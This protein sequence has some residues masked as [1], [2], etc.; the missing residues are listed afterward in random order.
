[1]RCSRARRSARPV[2]ACVTSAR[3]SAAAA[4]ADGASRSA[5][6]FERRTENIQAHEACELGRGQV[7]LVARFDQQHPLAGF[8]R[9]GRGD[10]VWRNE[11]GV[12][13][14]A[15]VPD[16]GLRAG[17]ALLEDALGRPGG[18]ERPERASNLEAKVGPRRRD[19]GRRRGRLRLR[20]ALERIAAAAVV[21]RPLEIEPRPVVVRH[22]RIDDAG[23]PADR[24]G[25]GELRDV[26]RARVSG[27][28]RDERLIGCCPHRDGSLGGRFPRPRLGQAMAGLLG[29]RLRVLER[30]EHAAPGLG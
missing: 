27:G 3:A 16:V 26:V 29:A 21:D 2:R 22:V 8:L 30:D 11:A 12:E 14:F 5:A 10:F 15:H 17:D 23:G 19:V 7:A 24:G 18:H 9:L 1:M 25:D 20:R 28:G 4:D 6:G 13:A